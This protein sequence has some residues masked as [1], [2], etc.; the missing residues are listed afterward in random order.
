MGDEYGHTRLEAPSAPNKAEEVNYFRW[1]AIDGS[2][3]VRP[4]RTIGLHS[5]YIPSLLDGSP[6]CVRSP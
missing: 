2:K 6:G 1:D 5:E 4:P 3:A